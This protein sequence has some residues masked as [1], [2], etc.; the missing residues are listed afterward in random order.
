MHSSCSG[1]RIINWSEDTSISQKYFNLHFNIWDLGEAA[2]QKMNVTTGTGLHEKPVKIVDHIFKMWFSTDPETLYHKI[3]ADFFTENYKNEDNYGRMLGLFSILNDSGDFS[4]T[5]EQHKLVLKSKKTKKKL[6]DLFAFEDGEWIIM[7]PD[8][9]Y[10]ASA[11]GDKYLSV[12][13]GNNIYGIENYR[14]AFFRPDL[15]KLA[16]AGNSL[17]G[18]RTLASIGSPPVIK[19]ENTPEKTSA[20]FVSVTVRITDTGGGVGD[21]RLYLNDTSVMTDSARS[22]RIKSVTDKKSTVKSYTLKLLNGDNTIKAIAFDKENNVQSNPAVQKITASYKAVKKPVMYALV[23]GINEYKNPKL[24]LKYATADAELFADTL[25]EAAGRL[26][27]KVNITRLTSKEAASKDNILKELDKY[28]NIN[29]DDI[30]AFYVASHGTVDDGEYYL[31]TSNVGALSTEKLKAEAITQKELRE[32]I[33]NVPAAKKLIV[34]DTC[35]AGK[36][37][38]QLQMAMLT[39]GMSE[40]TAMKIL[41]RAVGS[42]IISASTSLQE[43]LE[44]YKDHGLFTYVLTEG[45]RGKADASQSGYVKTSDLASYVEEKVPEIAESFFKRP[46]YPTKA[47]N[48]QDF[49]IGRIK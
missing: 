43:A 5:S 34:I 41:S 46:Q 14:E 27:D 33:A 49:P 16:L 22:V 24:T 23:I 36:L 31:I 19:I 13:M 37:G 47:V 15:V 11:N 2:L 39:R 21:V 25:Q 12:R 32:R 48:G 38:E 18:Y 44:G 9:Y 45:M 42:T 17:E 1:N 30:F 20:D 28:K 29:P 6:A 10:S 7:T 40:D 4:A 8:G 35:N 3:P 26:F